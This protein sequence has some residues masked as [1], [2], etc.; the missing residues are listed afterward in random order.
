M[1]ARARSL[2]LLF[3]LAITAAVIA[4]AEFTL[5]AVR[6]PV[7]P[8]PL[9]RQMWDPTE[10]AFTEADGMASA[11][12]QGR[13][14]VAPF[15]IQ[16]TPGRPRVMVFGESSVRAGSNLPAAQE[17]PAL[18]EGRLGDAGVNAEVLNLGRIGLDSHA[19]RTLVPEALRYHPAVVVYYYG[20]ND[21]GNAYFLARYSSISSATTAHVRAWAQRFQVY[22]S[23]RDLV[24]PAPKAPDHPPI[25]VQPDETQRALAAAEFS[26]NLEITVRAA[27]RAGAK[28]VLVT[29]ISRDGLYESNTAVC[30]QQ[31]PQGMWVVS[32][33][34][35][36]LHPQIM[37]R[38]EADAAADA[39]P[40]CPEARFV[41]GWWRQAD[42]D[43]T[44]GWADLRAARDL[45]PVPIRASEG[46][47]AATRAVAAH[48]GATLVDLVAA[49]DGI[50]AETMNDWFIDP[51]HPS[52]T[53]HRELADVL[54]PTVRALLTE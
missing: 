27:Q 24:M 5:R 2:R 42:G 31:V 1:K 51:V 25:P 30:P 35:Y 44:G 37:S 16:P 54:M 41:R 7:P 13:D 11:A 46:I 36:V 20:H 43:L 52:A 10:T 40:D 15:A 23:L 39:A 14:F 48:T 49:E 28:V 8:P 22:A 6:G 18:L 17:F 9:V 34:G 4:G 33:T 45:D 47:I 19:I 21:I 12:Y 29:S 26:A 38:G 50:K 3:S 32:R 53:G